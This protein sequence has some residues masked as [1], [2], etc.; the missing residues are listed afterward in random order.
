MKGPYLQAIVNFAP[1]N[2]KD[3]TPYAPLSHNSFENG[4]RHTHTSMH[5]HLPSQTHREFLKILKGKS[6]HTDTHTPTH[7]HTH[8]HTHICTHTHTHTHTHSLIHSLTHIQLLT[9]PLHTHILVFKVQEQFAQ[10]THPRTFKT[11]QNPP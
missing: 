1:I 7:T 5:V 11:L 8:T 10:S 3:S 9:T 6:T 2:Q 4:G